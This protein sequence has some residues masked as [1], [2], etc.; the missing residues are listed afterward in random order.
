MSSGKT[1]A[2][3]VAAVE[4]RLL[5]W[6]RSGPRDVGLQTRAVLMEALRSGKPLVEVTAA[7]Q[8]ID[9]DAAGNGSLMRTGPVAL[10]PGE[11]ADRAR[12]AAAVSALTHA[13]HDA[14]EACILWTAAIRRA[15][16]APVPSTGGVDWVDLVTAGLD[17]VPETH[18]GRWQGRLEECRT[19][20]AEEYTPN[21][22]V[23]SALQAALATLAQTEVPVDQPCRH[24][25]LAVERAVRIGDDTDTVAAIT[26]S[27]AGAVWGA[28]AV[29]LEWRRPLH[30]RIDYRSDP[31]RAA[32]L[33]RLAR[34]AFAGGD[35]DSSG[36]PETDSMLPHY[37]REWPA[38]PLAVALDEWVS[39]GNV[40]ALESQLPRV[41]V[42][43]SLCR[44]GTT[45]VPADIEHQVIGLLDSDAG[46]NPNLD[47]VLADT[48]HFLARCAGERRRVFVHCVQA[49]NR[50]P[51]VA[52]A[53]LVC[54]G[55]VAPGA[56]LDRIAGLTNARPQS[57]LAD[58]VRAL[59]E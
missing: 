6:M 2:A 34:L 52:A 15:I 51:A 47:F 23:V 19:M 10:A 43:V 48:A 28:T 14:V 37:R 20:P 39:I 55:G 21:G 58:A 41:D 27:L 45:D 35:N 57:F 16:D 4:S 31:V 24:L 22:W 42:V 5:A 33:E 7:W 40:H 30:G 50:T 13:N 25:R 59:A 36:W 53:Y 26:G 54:H 17:L 32:D 9:P 18:R 44:M 56:A 1:G 8:E 12:L 29:P 38:E 3:L 11:R 49:E 46:D